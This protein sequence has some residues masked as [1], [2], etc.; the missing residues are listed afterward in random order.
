MER[1]FAVVGVMTA[2][3]VGVASYSIYAYQKAN[4]RT[5]N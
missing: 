2:V 3:A 5:S 4:I 1:G